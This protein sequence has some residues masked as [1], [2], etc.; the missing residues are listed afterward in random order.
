MPLK[1][2]AASLESLYARL[3]KRDYVHPDPLEFLY[4]YEDIAD[5][6]IVA[7]IASSLAYGR[8]AQILKSVRNVLDRLDGS[9][10]KFVCDASAEKMGRT[11]SGFKHR[12]NTGEDVAG[13]L[14]AIKKI[15]REHVSLGASFLAV[16]DK[17][18]ATVMPALGRFCAMVRQAGPC[19]SLLPDPAGK[20]AMKRMNLMLRWLVRQDEVDVGGW[21]AALRDRLVVPLDTHMHKIALA[22]GATARKQADARTAQEITA[23]FARVVPDDP[24]RY[25]FA[26]TR[27]GIHPAAGTGSAFGDSGFGSLDLKPRIPKPESRNPRL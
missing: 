1:K 10:A 17:C 25:D 7:M 5:R 12:F 21:P 9:P 22:L 27:M 15:R 18:D 23:A 19:G 11:F 20:S 8:V 13:M 4:E 3:N 24:V 16:T 6:E 14:A 26:L 2:H